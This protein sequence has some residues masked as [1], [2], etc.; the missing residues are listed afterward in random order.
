[1]I[2]VTG[3]AIAPVK[4]TRLL[5]VESLSLDRDGAPGNRRFFVIDDRGRMQNSKQLGELV[6]VVAEYEDPGRRLTLTFPD[7][8]AVEG[9]V[10]TGDPVQTR[11]FSRSREARVVEGPWSIAL[12]EHCGRPLPAW[13]TSTSAGSGC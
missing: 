12:S 2:N 8:H 7:G 13:R 3:L 1:V 5:S 4:G 9:V 10:S 6:S 11:F